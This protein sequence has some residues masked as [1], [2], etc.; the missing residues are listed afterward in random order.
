MIRCL[1]VVFG[2][3]GAGLLV[4]VANELDVLATRQRI[5]EVHGSA[6]RHQ[7]HMLDTELGHEAD[8]VVR[9]LHDSLLRAPDGV[10]Q[11]SDGSVPS[12]LR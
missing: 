11:F 7:E 8:D 4:Q 9:E 3:D 5:I 2:G 10:D 6:A 12:V 1:G